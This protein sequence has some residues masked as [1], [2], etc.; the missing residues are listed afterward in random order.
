MPPTDSYDR[1]KRDCHM[2]WS[3]DSSIQPSDGIY[4]L[5]V[6][7]DCTYCLYCCSAVHRHVL[8]QP[9]LVCDDDTPTG[10]SNRMK[11]YG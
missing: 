5:N 3:I 8:H 9:V 2:V 7:W 11:P 1:T 10:V 6:D 4:A